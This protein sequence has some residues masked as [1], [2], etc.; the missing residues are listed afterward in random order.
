M[1]LLFALYPFLS[2]GFGDLHDS[3]NRLDESKNNS[4][5]DASRK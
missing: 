3:S 1:I 4:Q 5:K 2:A